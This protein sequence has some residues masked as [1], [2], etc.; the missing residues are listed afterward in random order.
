MAEIEK[1]RSRSFIVR[2]VS[3]AELHSAGD[4]CVYVLVKRRLS[5]P[6]AVSI[7]A[8]RLQGLGHPLG[9]KDTE[10][11]TAQLVCIAPCPRSPPEAVK[12]R[13]MWARLLG[14]VRSCRQLSLAG[15][16]FTIVL[17]ALP[18]YTAD[19]VAEEIQRM[20]GKRFPSYYSYQRFGTRRPSTHYAGLASLLEPHVAVIREVLDTPYPDEAPELIICRLLLWRPDRCTRGRMYE[21]HMAKDLARSLSRVA[22]FLRSIYSSALQASIFNAYL[23]LRI[24]EGIPLEKRLEGEKLDEHGRP[25]ALVPGVGVRNTP[26]GQARSILRRALELHGLTLED[27]AV[28]PEGL[29]K[30]ARP[31]WRPVYTEPMGLEANVLDERRVVVKFFLEKGQYATLLLREIVDPYTL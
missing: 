23:T 4:G 18:D 21:A 24:D 10:A 19:E 5:T 22:G 31:Y 8:R 6:E 28:A 12:A 13:G 14:R 25:L 7:L 2:E 29:L 26:K 17:R 11:T 20:R 3:R 30:R 1:P 15:N 27:L 16:Q 9:L